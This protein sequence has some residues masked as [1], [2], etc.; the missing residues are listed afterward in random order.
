MILRSVAQCVS[1]YVSDAH[2]NKCGAFMGTM[3]KPPP[4]TYV[5]RGGLSFFTREETSGTPVVRVAPRAAAAHGRQHYCAAGSSGHCST[6]TR[7][8]RIIS[9]I[10]IISISKLKDKYK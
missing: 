5:S 8:Q 7:W 6:S 2:K 1:H 3:S 4:L 10:N 9:E